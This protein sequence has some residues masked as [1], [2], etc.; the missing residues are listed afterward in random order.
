[1]MGYCAIFPMGQLLSVQPNPRMICPDTITVC[2]S[3]EICC[4]TRSSDYFYCPYVVGICCNDR[5][6]CCPPGSK[7]DLQNHTCISV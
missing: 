5:Q 6:R 3:N 7:C 2:N 4:E 1:M